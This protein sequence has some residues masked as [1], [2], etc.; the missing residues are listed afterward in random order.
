MS[1]NIIFL[2]DIFFNFK[3]CRYAVNQNNNFTVYFIY[4]YTYTFCN[5][6]EFRKFKINIS[7]KYSDHITMLF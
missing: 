6:I 3:I 2:N 1:S 4:I 5:V 7:C